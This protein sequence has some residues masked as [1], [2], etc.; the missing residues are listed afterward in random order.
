MIAGFRVKEEEVIDCS[1]TLTSLEGLLLHIALDALN[2]I[3]K[4][5]QLSGRM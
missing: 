4:Q 2:S 1:N 3:L 5:A